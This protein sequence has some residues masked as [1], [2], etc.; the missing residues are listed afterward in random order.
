MPD[1]I[2]CPV[3][4]IGKAARKYPKSGPT[5]SFEQ[6]LK[7]NFVP[8]STHP[9]SFE[10]IIAANP[11]PK[12]THTPESLI[13]EAKALIEYEVKLLDEIAATQDP[14]VEN[15]LQRRG[16]HDADSELTWSVLMFYSAVSTNKELRDASTE[17]E[18]LI[19]T[20]AVEQSVRPDLYQVYLKLQKKVDEGLAI[21]PESKRLLEKTIRDF[22]RNGLDLPEDKRQELKQIKLDISNLAT[23]FSRNLNEDTEYIEFTREELEG[24]PADVVAGFAQLENGKLRMT[25]KYPDVLPVLKYAENP[26]T[27][28]RAYIGNQDKV[29]QNADILKKIVQLRYKS[30][31]LLGYKTYSEYVLEERIAKTQDTVVDFLADLR[32]KLTPLGKQEVEKMKKFKNNYL[33]QKGLA[34]EDEYYFWD[35]DFY[36]NKLLEQEYQV[37]HNKIAEYF[38]LDTTIERMFALYEKLFD[39]KFVKVE[40]TDPALLWHEDVKR[41]AVFQDI[42][43]GNGPTFKG[44]LLLD[45]HPRE[46]KYGHAA[47]FGL[48][49]G[50]EGSKGRIHPYTALVCNF[51]KP[52][53][54]K[55]SLLKH[56]E[57]KTLFHEL[58]HGVHNL[59]GYTKYSSFHGTNVPRDFVETPSQMLEFWTW[60]KNELKSLSSHYQTGEPIPD[61]LVDLLIR[62]KHVNDALASLRQI[63]FGTFDMSLHTIDND[64]DI[65][66]IDLTKNWNDL[67]EDI[68]LLTSGGIQNKG[69]ATF[70]HLAGG[71]ESGY[72]GY[73]FSQVYANDIYYTLFKDDPLN[74]DNGV[75]YRDIVLKR[76]GSQEIL[77]VLKEL[78]GREPSNKA[79][80]DELLGN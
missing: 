41:F 27:R 67:R 66:A 65:E 58:G 75:R 36:T 62:T 28:K 57:V 73:L 78:L 48:G 4:R 53:A 31:K 61:A 38:A 72:Y 54:E 68:T 15:V 11:V 16:H 10:Q 50:G 51:T 79:F 74:T 8:K 49:P 26:D 47:N 69:Y 19:T 12:W 25:F 9:M 20:T 52:T 3:P 1:L 71:Y 7:V 34:P 35:A 46:G 2:D 13:A 77:D 39:L 59:V 64:A 45:L 43:R 30:A 14:T 18:I 63:H 32:D 5:M 29:P 22:K 42:T 6:L 21:D 60:S 33:K 24:V 17:A 80:L 55:P 76:G 70:G 56:N 37:D 44:Y 40:S 23:Q